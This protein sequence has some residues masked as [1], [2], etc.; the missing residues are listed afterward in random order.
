MSDFNTESLGKEVP[1]GM[2][3]KELKKLWEADEANT[4][5]SLMNL[6]VYTENPADLVRNSK[7][8]QELTREHSCRAV[9]IA[10]DR[11]AP[12]ASIRSWI[13]AHCH[14]SNGK[15]SVCS[16]QIAFLLSGKAI[17]RLRNTAFANM[18][19][20]LPLVFWWQGELSDLF[21]ERLYRLFDRLIIDSGSWKD[22]KSGF[23]KLA[24]AQETMDGKLLVQDLAWTRSFH[25]RVALAAL[26]DDPLA[27]RVVG[28]INKV[29]IVAQKEERMAALLLISWL[30][31]QAGWRDGQELALSDEKRTESGENY[32]F[33]SPNGGTVEVELIWDED[34]AALGLLEV[35]APGCLVRV[36]REKNSK[37][38]TQYLAAGGH[39]IE[40]SAPAD[41][42]D[43]VG[44]LAD[45]LSR[46][47]QNS[48]YQ[49]VLPGLL[50]LL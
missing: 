15:K 46:G 13:T 6:L 14:L 33:E 18:S 49:K 27:E 21:Q 1:V 39:K 43:E 28:E 40:L 31:T 3:Q 7:R 16:E 24:A 34:S 26:F 37:H 41:E 29:R 11:K 42:D 25:I 45:Q 23:D 12:E 50:R 38:L 22:A 48:L 36:A 35:H 2:I 9:L 47:G 44:L 30:A 20:D 32:F 10:M 17:G 5:A 19:S 4:K 8:V